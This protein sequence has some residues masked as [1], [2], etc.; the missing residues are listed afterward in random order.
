M[1]LLAI[2]DRSSVINKLQGLTCVCLISLLPSTAL[3][4]KKESNVELE[5][6]IVGDKEQP[7]VSFFVPWEDKSDSLDKLRWL[8]DN[9]TDK[10]LSTVDRAVLMRSITV[11]D[12]MNLETK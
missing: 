7:A 10:S 3:A 5:A 2:F 4:Q 8:D 9:N 1:R 12:A 11:Y 6:F